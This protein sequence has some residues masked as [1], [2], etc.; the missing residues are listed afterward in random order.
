[1]RVPH[2]LALATPTTAVYLPFR[3]SPCFCACNKGYISTAPAGR[4]SRC[5]CRSQ[6]LVYRRYPIL[7]AARFRIIPAQLF[8][9]SLSSPVCILRSRNE[10][11]FCPCINSSSLL[12]IFVTV[13]SV[14]QP[15][16]DGSDF[17]IGGLQGS[18]G[19]IDPWLHAFLLEVIV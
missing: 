10:L 13:H 5:S 17:W 1:M 8:N 12:L 15:P 16:L 11:N 6:L 2:K 18:V 19:L 14:G 7:R 3:C 4:P 9:S